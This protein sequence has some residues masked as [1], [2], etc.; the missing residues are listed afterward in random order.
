[1]KTVT[2]R[3]GTRIAYEEIGQGPALILVDGALCRRGFGP[4]P[5]LAPL[6]ATHFRVVYYDRRGRGDSGDTPPY[7]AERE[8]EDLRALVAAVGG[9]AFV[10]G[11]SSGGALAMRAVASG[12]PVPKLVLHEIPYVLD[13]EPQP[14]ERYRERI[15]EMLAGGRRGPAVALFMRVVG[16]PAFGVFMMRLMPNVW[17]KLKASAHTLPYDFA[18]LGD[19]PGEALPP[20]VTRALG[21]VRAPTLV[22]LGGKSP[23]WMR[24]AVETVA[25][26]IPGAQLRVLPGQQHNVAAKAI[27][28]ALIEFLS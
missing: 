25:K 26:A 11:T 14:P 20:E 1:M 2:S 13:S 4:S 27:A 10:Y 6:L 15:G 24:R 18:V 9:S 21:G 19:T 28:P 17:P 3:D 23:A 12:I 22:V 8:V 16:V 5:A 7:A